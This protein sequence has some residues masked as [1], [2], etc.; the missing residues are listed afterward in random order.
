MKEVPGG[1]YILAG[2]SDSFGTGGRNGWAV[3]LDSSGVVV[4]ER[5]YGGSDTDAFYSIDVTPEG[6]FVAV[7]DSYSWTASHSEYW[8]V[9]T[10]GTGTL[11]GPCPLVAT[12]STTTG[13]STSSST[14][15]NAVTA[16]V[17]VSAGT[18]SAS[19]AKTPGSSE[20]HCA[21]GGGILYGDIGP[22]GNRDG[23]VTFQDAQY[24][25]SISVG[26]FQ[27][28]A[29]ELSAGDVTPYENLDDTTSPWKATI[30][31]GTGGKPDGKITFTDAQSILSAS[32]NILVY[33]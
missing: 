7:G 14:D 21:S 10:D 24:G 19:V 5:R 18:S 16:S 20:E 12:T 11:G 33:E 27:P 13:T 6:G 9:K 17:L 32:L 4:G 29:T 23:K 3:R 15:T 1:G 31:D 30:G 22:R 2:H 26:L 25:L 8:V 28:D